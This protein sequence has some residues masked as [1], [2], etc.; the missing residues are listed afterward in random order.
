MLNRPRGV[1]P[2]FVDK[3]LFFLLQKLLLKAYLGLVIESIMHGFLSFASLLL[4]VH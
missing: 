4:R 3:L 2:I 1:W